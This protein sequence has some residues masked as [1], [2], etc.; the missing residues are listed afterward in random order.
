[1]GER[2]LKKIIKE[3]GVLKVVIIGK[4]VI[5]DRINSNRSIVKQYKLDLH[6]IPFDFS[7]SEIKQ[8]ILAFKKQLPSIEESI[9]SQVA[10]LKFQF[11]A[12]STSKKNKL[13]GMGE[14]YY[15]NEI[16]A[17]S[18]LEFDKISQFLYDPINSEFKDYFYDTAFELSQMIVIKRDNFEAFEHI[19]IHT[20]KLV[21]DGAI[22]LLGSKK[23]V[24]T[25][26]L[27]V[28]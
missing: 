24:T 1:M 6:H 15:L 10:D 14:E 18:L 5:N 3:T 16:K 8:I 26:A 2:I 28:C 12:I 25:I 19:F 20:Y 7:D 22:E 11:D 23:H 17:R 4:E 21:C 9:K 27:Y 13:N